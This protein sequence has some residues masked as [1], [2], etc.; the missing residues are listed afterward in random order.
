M[1]T[2]F[3]AA[4]ISF[5]AFPCTMDGKLGLLPKN[6][7]SFKALPGHEGISL[8]QYNKVID[9][10]EKIYAYDFQRMTPK[11][12]IVRDWYSE[13]VNAY[14]TL[15]YYSRIIDMKGGLARHP[16][17]TEDAFALVVCHEVGHHIGGFPAPMILSHGALSSEGQ[18]DYFSTLKCLRRYFLRDNNQKIVEAFNVPKE[19]K[20]NCEESFKNKEDVAICI[21]SSFAGLAFAKV[22][23]QLRGTEN[24]SLE[25]PEKRKALVTDHD[26]PSP[27]CRLDTFVQGAI[28]PAPLQDDISSTDETS[29][30]CHSVNNHTKGM[31][32]A[33][34]FTPSL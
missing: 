30:V 1:K 28:C 6:K 17:M 33:C 34:W 18:A 2:L 26:Y 7:L 20:E 21:R 25:S 4:F 14:A 23:A 9:H 32:P 10:V 31:R 24:P 13:V 19:L 29:G 11:L 16:L 12:T 22:S 8:Q 27:Q 3:L 5:S 15:S